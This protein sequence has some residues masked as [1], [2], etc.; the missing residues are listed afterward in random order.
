MRDSVLV[1]YI[2][3]TVEGVPGCDGVEEMIVY[4]ALYLFGLAVRTACE[5]ES[6][7]AV[8]EGLKEVRVRYRRVMDSGMKLDGW[9][10]ELI[11]F[12]MVQYLVDS[13]KSSEC[14]RRMVSEVFLGGEG[15][16]FLSL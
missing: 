15:T 6:Y 8:R 9:D 14:V 4:N 5:S 3:G 12:F 1:E 2:T 16:G 10:A 13:M 7:G 11:H